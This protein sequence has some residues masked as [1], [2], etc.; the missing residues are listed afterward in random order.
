MRL[1]ASQSSWLHYLMN[2]LLTLPS[3]C[4]AMA[5]G[6]VFLA[7]GD[8]TWTLTNITASNFHN[9]SASDGNGG[10]LSLSGGIQLLANNTFQENTAANAGG[11][12]EF[13]HSCTD[14]GTFFGEQHVIW[15]PAIAEF[16]RSCYMSCF[17][18]SIMMAVAQSLQQYCLQQCIYSHYVLLEL[19]SCFQ[20]YHEFV[21]AGSACLCTW[22]MHSPFDT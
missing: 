3:A 6:A 12:L 22:T 4:R 13:Q 5:G 15:S 17:S 7:S 2:L 19:C 9:N 14:G 16:Y 21:C 18:L 8:A 10:A 20:T 11:A 1:A